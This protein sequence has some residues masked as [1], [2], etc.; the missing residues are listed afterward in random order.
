MATSTNYE[1]IR[2]S[3][4]N[5]IQNVNASLAPEVP[6][7]VNED[8]RILFENLINAR[9]E[10][11]AEFNLL[12]EERLKIY[13]TFIS[14]IYIHI[15][16]SKI[17]NLLIEFKFYFELLN[18]VN[19]FEFKNA[20]SELFK[21]YSVNINQNSEG[22]LNSYFTNIYNSLKDIIYPNTN[23][24][25]D[26]N[27]MEMTIEKAVNVIINIDNID[28]EEIIDDTDEVIFKFTD[29]ILFIL[30]VLKEQNANFT[31]FIQGKALF[32][33]ESF[34]VQIKIELENSLKKI[35]SYLASYNII[36]LYLEEKDTNYS[37]E[38]ILSIKETFTELEE[39]VGLVNNLSVEGLNVLNQTGQ[40]DKMFNKAADLNLKSQDVILDAIQ[41]LKLIEIVIEDYSPFIKM[42]I[43]EANKLQIS[44]DFIDG[45][46]Q[47]FSTITTTSIVN[48][49]VVDNYLEEIEFKNWKD[50]L[51]DTDLI[52]PDIFNMIILRVGIFLSRENFSKI[53]GEELIT[54]SLL[55]M[56]DRKLI[57]ESAISE[58]F[59]DFKDIE[60]GVASLLKLNGIQVKPRFQDDIISFAFKQIFPP[61]EILD[62]MSFDEINNS[63]QDIVDDFKENI[64]TLILEAFLKKRSELDVLINKIIDV[65][66]TRNFNNLK[67]IYVKMCFYEVIHR[68]I[69]YLNGN[70][71][72][73]TI[74]KDTLEVMKSLIQESDITDNVDY[75]ELDESIKDYLEVWNYLYNS[76]DDT[77]FVDRVITNLGLRNLLK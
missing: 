7:T 11:S 20:L 38:Y 34:V 75:Q 17:Q 70:I 50:S 23:I 45:M 13:Q 76:N 65:L 31:N 28:G 36:N 67:S 62:Y 55:R 6:Q 18:I 32:L 47:Y 63:N 56:I 74:T 58:E 72:N 1:K 54:F 48:P 37:G 68:L 10:F 41:S 15:F 33:Q 60:N 66:K 46:K 35:E 27:D 71:S 5:K 24:T 69:S 43:D 16:N 26:K 9:D 25:F 49:F 39:T 52:N 64:I 42:P 3:L 29:K 44:M 73:S 4:T 57:S 51:L 40:I 19:T 14:L 21:I 77:L 22:V 30:Q 2:N 12:F 61:L 53:S 8:L 59:K